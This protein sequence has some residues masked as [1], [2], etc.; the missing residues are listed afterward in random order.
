MILGFLLHVQDAEAR[1]IEMF[2][3]C[4]GFYEVHL[5]PP[6]RT[7]LNPPAAG[8]RKGLTFEIGGGWGW[9]DF[10]PQNIG[11]CCICQ[12]HDTPEGSQK[13]KVK[14]QNSQDY[15]SLPLDNFLSLSY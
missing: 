9:S 1:R 2:S 15:S 12:N 3:G 11:K 4:F 10:V 8:G 13:S 14:S 5:K 6:P 7:P